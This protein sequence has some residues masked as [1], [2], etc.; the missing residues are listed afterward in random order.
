[1]RAALPKELKDVVIDEVNAFATGITCVDEYDRVEAARLIART[2]KLQAVD[3]VTANMLQ[4]LLYSLTG[5][6][7]ERE[8]ALLNARRNHANDEASMSEFNH[9]ANFLFA[10]DAAKL[11][12]HCLAHRADYPF[13]DVACASAAVGMFRK[14]RD[15]VAASRARNEVLQVTRDLDLIRAAADVLDAAGIGDEDVLRTIDLAGEVARSHRVIWQ[16]NMPDLRVLTPEQGGPLV[17]LAYRYA[18]RPEVASEMSWSLAELMTDHGLD[19]SVFQVWFVGT[20][21]SAP[22][23]RQVQEL[24]PA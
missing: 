13:M 7:E 14:V 16:G 21:L 18:V 19:A 1:M 5:R 11:V 22:Q 10:Q 24:Q 20:D 9:R 15:Y 6:W 4:A 12:D 17:A 8:A 23:A 3:V 2:N